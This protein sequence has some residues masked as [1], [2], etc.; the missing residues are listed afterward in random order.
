MVHD[1]CIEGSMADYGSDPDSG[2]DSFSAWAAHDSFG[3]STVD[4]FVPRVNRTRV[5]ELLDWIRCLLEWTGSSS[6]AS[7]GLDLVSYFSA[8]RAEKFYFD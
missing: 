8:E 1:C 5:T 7:F 6:S 3:Y 4:G 2:V